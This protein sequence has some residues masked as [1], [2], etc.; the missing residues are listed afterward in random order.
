M[1]RSTQQAS[2]LEERLEAQTSDAMQLM[3]S[4]QSREVVAMNNG[5][6]ESLVNRMLTGEALLSSLSLPAPCSSVVLPEQ[7]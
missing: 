5:Y 1:L 7:H 3:N 6:F 4:P 2:Q